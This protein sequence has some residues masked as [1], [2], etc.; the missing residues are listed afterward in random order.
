M[1]LDPQEFQQRRLQRQQARETARRRLRVR[2]ILAAIAL[3]ACAVII[4]L[5][6][7]NASP[8]PEPTIPSADTVPAQTEAVQTPPAEAITSIRIAAVGDVNIT[9]RV[10]A[11]GTTVQDYNNMLLDVSHLLADPELTLM[12]LEGVIS[13]PPYGDSRSAPA[14]LIQALKNSGID[15]VQLANS[16]TIHSGISGLSD[17]VSALEEEHLLP[18]GAYRNK[19]KPY[20]VVNVRGIRIAIA[21]FTK[22]T[23]G[24]GMLEKGDYG[25][26]ILYTDY[27]TTYQKVD[28]DRIQAILSD[29]R[30]EKP[31]L[32]IALVHWG[33]EFNDNISK[34]QDKIKTILQ[35]G[36]VNAIIG[37]HSHFVQ[38]MELNEN[39][40]FIAYSL[41][42]F[43]GDGTRAGTEY[44]LIL[45]LSVE[46]NN[47]TGVTR[48]TGFDYT[49][50]FIVNAEDQPLKVV[51]LTEA[52]AAYEAGQLGRVDEATYDA[53][54]YALTRVQ[55]R[56]HPEADK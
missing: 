19:E 6:T 56:V 11:S 49:P 40:Q 54:R 4:V 2:L 47:E 24:M 31:D 43:L 1:A 50:T 27:D 25:T 36:G 55:A 30:G 16:Y 38:K 53:M 3:L 44:S 51:R 8:A 34:T 17:T 22:G 29:I 12:N 14:E 5:V 52:I 10:V 7:R 26:N 45:N 32:T 23:V 35:E 9:Q 15:G 20:T 39:G 33:S 48:I 41:G 46:K 18:L 42:D 21:A 28:T 37:T 13:G